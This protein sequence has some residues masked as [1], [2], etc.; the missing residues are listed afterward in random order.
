MNTATN[1]AV[2]LLK[3][4]I[5][6]P[7]FSREE[8]AAAD[9]IADFI[10]KKAMNMQRVG[11]NVFSVCRDFADNKPTLLLDAH[12]DTVKVAKGWNHDPFT[13]VVEDGNL[14]GLGSNDDGG[15]LVSLLEA[16]IAMCDEKRNYK[17]E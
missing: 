6:V 11:N 7:S 5:A 14:Y 4:L 17:E 8:T 12:I 13:P 15:S 2:A 16:Y 10:G 1:E 9:K 3:E